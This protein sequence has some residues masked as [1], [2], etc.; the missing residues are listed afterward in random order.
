MTKARLIAS[1]DEQFE[2]EPAEP[3]VPEELSS[4]PLEDCSVVEPVSHGVVRRVETKQSPI[5]M[6]FPAIMP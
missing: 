5:Y 6:F 3:D 1:V 4:V 2:N